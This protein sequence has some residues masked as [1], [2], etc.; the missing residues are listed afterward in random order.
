MSSGDILSSAAAT[1]NTILVEE[2]LKAG[3]DP[4][5][6]NA[7]GRTPLQ[8]GIDIRKTTPVMTEH[9]AYLEGFLCTVRVLVQYNA[10]RDVKD[11]NNRLPIDLAREN[12]HKDVVAFLEL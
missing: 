1:G 5:D 8:V 12:G 6:V 9:D 4:N 3:I 2:L 10:D 7:F 11:N